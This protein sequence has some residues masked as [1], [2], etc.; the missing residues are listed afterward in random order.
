MDLSQ[1]V[2]QHG[3]SIVFANVLLHQLGV[4][5]PAMPMLIIAGALVADGTLELAPLFVV[6]V[7]ASLLGD[8]PWYYAGRRYGYRILRTVCRVSMEPETCVKQTE[9]I[10]M[11]YGAAS[12]LVAKYIPGFSTVAPPLAGTMKLA[13]GR[14][15]AYSTA[16]ALIWAALP[17][18]G[19][20]YFQKQVDWVLAR[21]SETGSGA[22]AAVL[23]L[24]AAYIAFK[25]VERHLL[26]RF[27][28]MVRV[29][30]AELREMLARDPPPL[31]LD[32]RSP[33]AR[34][35]E[36]RRIPGA[37]VVTLDQAE[38]LVSTVPE[39]R[40]VVVYCS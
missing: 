28:R 7:V 6:V 31:I 24:V 10:F 35:V 37:V 21:I 9:N 36:P 18:A 23:G 17:V 39:D 12:L 22:I 16:G 5:L 29:T 40:D 27:L 14:F 3:L 26:I 25:V 13:P 34:E 15:I 2:A 19:G 33:L 8:I 11:R 4:P 30:V 38:A 32:V 1:L 20:A